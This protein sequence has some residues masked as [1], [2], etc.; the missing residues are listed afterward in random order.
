VFLLSR[1]D[2]QGIYNAGFENISIRDIAE[3]A[4]KHTG[5]KIVIKPS[6]D[7]RSYRVSSA[8]LLAKGFKPKKTVEHAV[9][10]IV[11]AFKAGKLKDEDRYYNLKWMQHKG[12]AGV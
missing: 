4:A 11:E 9:S 2:I 6:N 12:L 1:P 8:K 3:L 10:E 7:P 5:A